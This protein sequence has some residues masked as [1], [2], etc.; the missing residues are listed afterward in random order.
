MQVAADARAA[1]CA[2]EFHRSAC[3]VALGRTL[4]ILMADG[5]QRRLVPQNFLVPEH[6]VATGRDSLMYPEIVASSSVARR[7]EDVQW[8]V[9][10]GVMRRVLAARIS[11][12]VRWERCGL[13][14]DAVRRRRGIVDVFAF[15]TN[16]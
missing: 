13:D 9:N 1:L 6:V 7:S 3:G 15:V 4:R 12:V 16:S 2:E 5:E 10:A 14:E 8:V 11:R